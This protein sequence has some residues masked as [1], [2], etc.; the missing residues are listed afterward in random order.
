[1][2]QPACLDADRPE[3]GLEDDIPTT[4]QAS[5]DRELP[6]RFSNVVAIKLRCVVEK[7]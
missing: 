4:G 6:P 5:G 3:A 1:M 7:N 2:P